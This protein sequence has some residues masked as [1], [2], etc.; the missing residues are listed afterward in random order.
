MEVDAGSFAS[1]A[2][3]ASDTAVGEG[4]ES[5]DPDAVG[6]VRAD[7]QPAG[8]CQR[9]SLPEL[10]GSPFPSFAEDAESE[11]LGDV[12]DGEVRDLGEP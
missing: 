5:P 1:M 6:V 2:D 7:A 10:D 9:G 11:I 4:S 3:D 8:E 12:T